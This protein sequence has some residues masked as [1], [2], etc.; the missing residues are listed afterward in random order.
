M[1]GGM[2]TVMARQRTARRAPT[3]VTLEP[4]KAEAGCLPP[5]NLD[6]EAAVISAILLSPVALDDAT[7]VLG[8]GDEGRPKFYSH[9][10]GLIYWAAHQ[11]R[12]R[13]RA[14]D[15]ISVAEE[16]RVGEQLGQVGGPSYLAQLSDAT[17]FVANVGNHAAIVREKW[18][19]RQIIAMCQTTAAEGYGDYGDFTEY[20]DRL[21]QGIFDL[22]HQ[23]DQGALV[24]VGD[25]LTVELDR[26][27][28]AGGMFGIPSGFVRLD[29]YTAGLHAGELGILAARPGMGKSSLAMGIGVNVAALAVDPGYDD[30]TDPR[31]DP[32][33]KAIEYGVAVFSLEMPREQL[34]IRVCCSE[35]RVSLQKLRKGELLQPDWDLLAESAAWLKTIPLWIDDTPGI[36]PLQLRAKLRRVKARWDRPRNVEKKQ[37]ERRLGLVLVDYIQLM[38]SDLPGRSREEEI[39]RISGSC[40]QIAKDFAVPVVALAQLNRA[41][42]GRGPKDKKPQLSDLRDS[43][44]LEQDADS[45]MFIYREEYYLPK[46]ENHG[47]AEIVIAKQRSGPENRSTILRWQ[48]HCTRFSDY[49]DDLRS[50]QCKQDE[51]DRAKAYYDALKAKRSS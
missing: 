27:R 35:A 20:C 23:K 15:I 49:Y 8:S 32:E 3:I 33:Y 9:A 51:F 50:G 41:V 39:G 24:R 22:G 37:R 42:E 18:F 26:V 38:G 46:P 11:V 12:A 6:A 16:L 25:V 1:K 14:V 2:S 44:A 45:V 19:V 40:K 28:E 47:I 48:P 43:G 36:T 7:I 4:T 10:N 21:E 30:P 5:H 17:P 31:F 34:A 13:G 29:T